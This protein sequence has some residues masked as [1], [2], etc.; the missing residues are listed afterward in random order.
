MK[1]T[2][3]YYHTVQKYRDGLN[4]IN[5]R[6]DEEV[7]QKA[8]YRGSAQ[9]DAEIS[10]LGKARAAEIKALREECGDAFERCV[11][12]MEKN[13]ESRPAV[14]PSPEQLSILQLLKMKE[15]IT[16]DELTHACNSLRG[17]SM[18]LAVLEEIAHTH[19]ILGFSTGSAGV[20]DEF[21]RKA[22][23][24][25]AK[26]AKHIL[27]LERTNQRRV[28]LNPAG[29]GDGPNGTIP[30][31][32]AITKFRIDVDPKSPEDAASRFG[33]VP[34]DCYPAFCE[35]VDTREG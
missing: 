21:A 2:E 32:D 11:S 33:D 14:A 16:R 3:W 35:A 4:R 27:A 25:L 19:Q 30:R 31:M 28:Y 7:Q 5:Q 10:K 26:N 9:Y 6:F 13:L 34:T 17:C 29:T 22:I 20:S 1:H 24:S 18:A 8:G 12:S 23:R 15:R